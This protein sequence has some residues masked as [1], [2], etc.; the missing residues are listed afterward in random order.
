[1]GEG[2][3][4]KYRTRIVRLPTRE[5]ASLTARSKI[6]HVVGTGTIGE[7]LIGLFARHRTEFGLDGVTFYKHSPRATDRPMVN[8]LRALGAKL[9][10]AAERAAEFEAIGLT[11]DLTQ[12]EALEQ[13]AVVID[14]TPSDA[15]LENKERIYNKLND[16][17]RLFMAQGSEGGFGKKYAYGINDESLTPEDAFLH[18]VSCNT[19]NI[20]VLLK[21]LGFKDAAAAGA[22]ESNKL[23]TEGRFVC[24]RRADDVGGQKLVLSPKVDKHKDATYGTH[25]AQDVANLYDTTLN[26]DL[27][28]FSSALKLPTPF[29][30]TIWFNLKLS[31]ATTRENVIKA[32]EANPLIGMTE[33]DMTN[34][35]FSFGREH[36]PFGR[37]LSQTVVVAPSLH[38]N[39]A[40]TEVTGF[41][42]TPQDGNVLITNIAATLRYIH[43]Q[44]WK[45]RFTAMDQYVKQEY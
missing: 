34:L 14:S 7:P 41:C 38:V 16:G 36:G 24:I 45:K 8:A 40:G 12:E 27:N 18:I 17:T 3:I 4:N 1:M 44:D 13:A 30:H 28:V 29:M 11:P 20:S 2:I 25:H 15:G 42:F 31:E 6:V 37:V 33:K 35:V 39:A 10:V 23:V 32:L 5:G 43:P 21:T 19:H 22:S 26:V 9:A